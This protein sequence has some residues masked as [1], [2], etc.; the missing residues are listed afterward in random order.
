[1]TAQEG[2]FMNALTMVQWYPQ[3][4]QID[5]CCFSTQVLYVVDCDDIIGTKCHSC[6]NY[7]RQCHAM[8]R[9]GIFFTSLFCANIHGSSKM[10]ATVLLK[11]GCYLK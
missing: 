4:H 9:I 10:N 7:I 3:V 5:P 2:A 1:M 8:P 6:D 11:I